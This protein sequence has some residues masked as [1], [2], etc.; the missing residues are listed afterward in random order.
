MFRTQISL[1]SR[2]CTANIPALKDIAIEMALKKST[3][4]PGKQITKADDIK[5]TEVLMT[6]MV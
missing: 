3:V 6:K 2:V 1:C 4:L 5:H